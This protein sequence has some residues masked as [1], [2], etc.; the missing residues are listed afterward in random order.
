M[1]FLPFRP[2]TNGRLR[3]AR[4]TAGCVFLGALALYGLTLITYAF[5]GDSASWIAWTSGLDPREVPTRPI[6]G[7]L[8]RWAMGCP[9]FPWRYG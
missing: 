6:L 4:L 8:G 1:F 9:S 2:I 7:A 3:R 5:P